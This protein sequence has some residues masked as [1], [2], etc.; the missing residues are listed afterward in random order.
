MNS[1]YTRI[2]DKIVLIW[3]LVISISILIDSSMCSF[4]VYYEIVCV[5]VIKLKK[6]K[7]EFDFKM[8]KNM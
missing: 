2:K 6:L 5:C 8:K 1:K 4:T 3:I 7:I